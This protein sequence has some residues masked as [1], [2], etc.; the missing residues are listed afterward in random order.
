MVLRARFF[1]IACQEFA[2]QDDDEFS[3]VSTHDLAPEPLVV[4]VYVSLLERKSNTEH[5]RKMHTFER[6]PVVGKS[7]LLL[8]P[9]LLVLLFASR[10]RLYI[11]V[12]FFL[13]DL[14]QSCSRGTP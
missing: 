6:S 4:L 14:A 1:P 12:C 13:Q 5:T 3:R 7:G 11:C 2:C 10:D 8:A 9:L